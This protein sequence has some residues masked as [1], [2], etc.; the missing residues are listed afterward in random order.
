MESHLGIKF[1]VEVLSQNVHLL[2]TFGK[3]PAGNKLPADGLVAPGHF[4]VD[5]D[6][7]QGIPC[8]YLGTGEG[9]QGNDE[10]FK[11]PAAV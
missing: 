5:L 8:E 9:I 10:C 3:W 11:K 7:L 1:G 6:H 2:G 4:G